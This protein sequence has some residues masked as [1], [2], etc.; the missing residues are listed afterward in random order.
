MTRG[1]TLL[2]IIDNDKINY[3]NRE[4]LSK[5]IRGVTS[6][7]EFSFYNC[8]SNSF[9]KIM[10]RLEVRAKC[11]FSYKDKSELLK[12]ASNKFV[13]EVDPN[14]IYYL[15]NLDLCKSYLIENKKIDCVVVNRAI[16]PTFKINRLHIDNL[17][18]YRY[19]KFVI[20]KEP[21]E[22]KLSNS[23]M[24][25]ETARLLSKGN[26]PGYVQ[27]AFYTGVVYATSKL[28]ISFV[29]FNNVIDWLSLLN[30]SMDKIFLDKRSLTKNLNVILGAGGT[31][32][33][34]FIS[35]DINILNVYNSTDWKRIF[36]INSIDALL[37]EHVFEHLSKTQIERSLEFCYQYL[38]PG[39]RLRIAIPDKNR[40][41][42]R[43]V[44]AVKPP[45]DGHKSYLNLK[46]LSTLLKKAGFRVVPLEYFDS[47]GVFH[48]RHWSEKYGKIKRSFKRDK[49]K[50]FKY[51]SLHY[52]SLIVDA[53]K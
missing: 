46:E 5:L 34:N 47:K 43:Y 45:I 53:I 44:K 21:F 13:I 2:C 51:Q 4:Y 8:R 50:E 24:R 42:I 11:S 52:T 32:Q 31:Y 30:T 19:Y 29:Y 18:L 20:H 16:I 15:S 38:K 10:N 37:A 1:N 27:S 28:P 7:I 17:L 6:D 12:N 35:T 23:I 25:T 39:G 40:K 48:K 33:K 49:Q 26:R 3:F 9:E 36:D 22:I 14:K 41:D